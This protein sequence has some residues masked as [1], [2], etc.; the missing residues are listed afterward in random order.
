[1]LKGLQ[2]LVKQLTHFISQL[3]VLGIKRGW[4]AL[5]SPVLLMRSLCIQ[6]AQ[7]LVRKLQ[8]NFIVLWSLNRD[9]WKAGLS[10]DVYQG[11][12]Q[13]PVQNDNYQG[14]EIVICRQ[15]QAL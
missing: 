15:S 3:C 8:D 1:M 4:R 2:C 10:Y 7:S 13:W 11:V 9:C 5:Q 12:Y 6:L 14:L